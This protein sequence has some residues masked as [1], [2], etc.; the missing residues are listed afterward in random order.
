[1]RP[2]CDSCFMG[3]PATW[4]GGRWRFPCDDEARVMSETRRAR[5]RWDAGWDDLM[6]ILLGDKSE[7]MNID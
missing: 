6:G 4:E 2:V 7:N 5:D 3:C 1:M